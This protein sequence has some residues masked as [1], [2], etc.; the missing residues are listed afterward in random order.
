MPVA[1]DALKRIEEIVASFDSERTRIR[2]PDTSRVYFVDPEL[3]DRAK[4]AGENF[5]LPVARTYSIFVC[6]YTAL[7]A[8]PGFTDEALAI[9]P[10]RFSQKRLPLT[11]RSTSSFILDAFGY[12]RR[13]DRPRDI[14]YSPGPVISSNH[15]ETAHKARISDAAMAYFGIQLLRIAERE[16]TADEVEKQWHYDYMADFFRSGGYGFPMREEANSFIEAVDS[17][18]SGDEHTDLWRNGLEAA[19]V[20]ETGQTIDDIANSLPKKSRALYLAGV[21]QTGKGDSV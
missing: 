13:T 21:A 14:L 8:I 3:G 9:Q 5:W 16:A 2:L 7:F 10:D 1:P 11:I 6:A 20:L 17:E 12:D 19:R 4:S 15:R 18:L